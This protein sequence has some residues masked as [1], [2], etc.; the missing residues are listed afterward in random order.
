M[1]VHLVVSLFLIVVVLLQAGKGASIGA[2]FGGSNQALF[3]TSQG[4]FIG[5]VTAVAATIFMLTSLALAYSS[6]TAS[7]SSVMEGFKS[8]APLESQVIPEEIP[9]EVPLGSSDS[10]ATTKAE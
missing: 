7:N 8:P 5:K 1:I 2:T 10:D 3:G 4:S 6:S 9:Q